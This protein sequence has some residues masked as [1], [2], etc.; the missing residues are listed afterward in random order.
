MFHVT[1]RGNRR[2]PIYSADVDYRLFLNIAASVAR[3]FGWV[4]TAYCLMPNHYHL[5]I[6]TPNAGLSRGMHC[7]NSTYAHLFNERYGFAGHLFQGRFHSVLIESSSHL[8][9]V[10]RYVVLNPVRAALCA[11]P[12]DWRWSSYRAMV[13]FEAPDP[14]LSASSL[15]SQF[16]STAELARA[17]FL[18]FVREGAA[19][20]A[21]RIA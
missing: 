21:P 1:A 19:A 7:L 17:A 18:A 11:H 13:G 12:A 20:S 16:G 10:A 8:L 14:L 6:E 9:E 5:A 15:V 3:K 2:Q 4:C